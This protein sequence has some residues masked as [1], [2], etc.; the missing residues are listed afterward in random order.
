MES[1][2]W[3]LDIGVCLVGM[4]LAE[5]INWEVN[6]QVAFNAVKLAE[7]WEEMALWCL[8]AEDMERGQ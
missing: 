1:S 8:E 6:I 7:L 5:G 2:I 4:I 3:Q